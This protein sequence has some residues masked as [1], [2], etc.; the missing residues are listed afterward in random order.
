MATDKR[1][2]KT[3]KSFEHVHYHHLPFFILMP[4]LRH[5]STV[6]EWKLSYFYQNLRFILHHLDI[7]LYKLC[8]L[9]CSTHQKT[10]TVLLLIHCGEIK[11]RW[12]V[13]TYSQILI[14]ASIFIQS[15]SQSTN[16]EEV[17][18]KRYLRSRTKPEE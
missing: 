3:M 6:V 7:A 10:K 18:E 5:H 12:S 17:W 13:L 15:L 14:H 2:K 16:W 4:P 1:P 8:R 11:N 9:H